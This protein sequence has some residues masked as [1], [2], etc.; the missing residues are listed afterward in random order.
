MTADTCSRRSGRRA[1][2]RVLLPEVLAAGR[3]AAG[4]DLPVRP[5]DE[6]DGVTVHVPLALLA[7]LLPAGFDWQV[8]GLRDELVTALIKSLPKAIRR[9][10]VPAADWASRLMADLPT[11]AA[12]GELTA[13]LAAQIQRADLHADHRG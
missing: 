1:G 3:P 11:D 10:V 4:A 7:R 12:E 2:R 6:E 5:G 13:R 8:P 9:N